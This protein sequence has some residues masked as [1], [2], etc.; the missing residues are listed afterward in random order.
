MSDAAPAPVD[1]TRFGVDAKPPPRDAP[2]RDSMLRWLLV[3]AALAAAYVAGFLTS[4][5]LE[6]PA[7]APRVGVGGAAASGREHRRVAGRRDASAGA[8][9]ASAAA[10]RGAG[11]ARPWRRPPAT[12]PKQWSASAAEPAAPRSRG[13]ACAAGGS[14]DGACDRSRGRS[15]GGLGRAV[16]PRAR[17]SPPQPRSVEVNVEAEPGASILVDGQPVGSGTVK[18]LELAPGPH[19]VEVRLPDGRAV[20]RVIDVKGTRYV[21]KVR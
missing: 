14:R 10:G 2:R 7:V 9:P 20:E 4:Q 5:T 3:P 11:C 16:R 18:G 17:R 6:A 13:G 19:L 15:A 12:A 1:P 21:V 8:A